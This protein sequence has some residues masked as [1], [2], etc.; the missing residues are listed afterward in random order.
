MSTAH[1]S[2]YL[3]KGRRHLITPEGVDLQIELADV[4]ARIGAFAIDLTIMTLTLIA[5][6]YALNA[7]G[8]RDSVGYDTTYA[9]FTLIA[10]FLRSFYFTVF[11]MGRR[12]ATPG[13]MMMKI[14][15]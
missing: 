14:G 4:G 1:Y 10:F 13:K 11:E 8:L 3:P 2:G 5:A 6:M 15:G 7:A 9:I 12:A